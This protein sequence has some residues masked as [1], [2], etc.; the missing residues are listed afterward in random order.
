M[1]ESTSGGPRE[2]G[3]PAGSAAERIASFRPVHDLDRIR[4]EAAVI[5]IVRRRFAAAVQVRGLLKATLDLLRT[6]TQVGSTVESMGFGE[7]LRNERFPRVHMANLAWVDAAPPGGPAEVLAALDRAY[8]GTEV[9]HRHALFRDAMRAYELQDAFLALGFRPTAELALARL[10]APS[11]IVNPEV[12]VREVDAATPEVDF[13]SVTEAVHRDL[14]YEP[15]DSRQVY[16]LDRERAARIGERAYVAYLGSDAAGSYT[17]WVRGGYAL[18]GNV[19]TVPARRMRGIGRT[20][21]HDACTRAIDLHAEWTL[22]TTALLGT[23]RTMYETLGFQ[24]IGE[25]RGFLRV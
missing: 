7:I 9:R 15:E 10:G 16:E 18:I 6:W 20:M 19:G 8:L 3:R 17:L 22:L 1:G 13:R 14:G 5:F 11:C 2:G 4:A 25:I 23:P 12:T 21:I 24:P